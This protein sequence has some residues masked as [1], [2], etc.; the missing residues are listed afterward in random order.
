MAG[1][2]KGGKKAAETAKDKYGKGFHEE[3]GKKE[4]KETDHEKGGSRSG[5]NR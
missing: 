2:S 1:T 3:I 4:G 5:Q